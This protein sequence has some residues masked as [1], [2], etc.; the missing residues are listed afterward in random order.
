[1]RGRL[2]DWV[3][4]DEE[5]PG[6]MTEEK[7][8]LKFQ[9]T[10]GTVIGDRII[11]HQIS[12][13]EACCRPLTLLESSILTDPD[14]RGWLKKDVK[15]EYFEDVVVEDYDHPILFLDKELWKPDDRVKVTLELMEDL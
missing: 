6:E 12:E 13:T 1:M 3:R 9:L 14:W 11:T 15:C 5:K 4:V 8:S 2:F 7:D 10:P